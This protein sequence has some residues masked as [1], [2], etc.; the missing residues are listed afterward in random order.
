MLEQG[1]KLLIV[2]RR[3]FEKDTPRFFVGEVQAYEA[4]MA[5]VKGYTFVKDL[6]GGNMKRKSASRT[7]IM[8]IVSGTFIVYQL[9]VTVLLDSV[10]FDLDQDGALVL[11]DDGGFS[12]DV[13]E[14]MHKHETHQ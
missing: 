12:M 3:L 13:A 9:P 1:E 2:H 7:K 14:S 4:G 10:R 8:S 6:F 11:K 5:K